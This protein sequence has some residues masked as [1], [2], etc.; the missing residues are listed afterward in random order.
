MAIIMPGGSI[1][2]MVNILLMEMMVAQLSVV[3]EVRLGVLSR[4]CLSDNFI[5]LLSIW[6][7]RTIFSVACRIMVLGVGLVKFGKMVVFAML[8]GNEVSFGDGF[9]ILPDPTDARYLYSMWQGGNLLYVDL[10]TGQQNYIRP[11]R[12]RSRITLQLECRYCC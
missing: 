9:D 1:L 3:I 2:Q 12:F 10:E 6:L 5:I 11:H 7:S 4:T 8:T